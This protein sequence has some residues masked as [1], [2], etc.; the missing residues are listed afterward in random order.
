MAFSEED[1]TAAFEETSKELPCDCGK[2]VLAG[3][4][5]GKKETSVAVSGPP[6]LP[7]SLV[8]GNEVVK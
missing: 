7:K 5:E 1:P 6:C 8:E 4:A 3:E 2:E